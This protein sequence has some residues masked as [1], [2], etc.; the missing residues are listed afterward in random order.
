MK[1]KEYTSRSRVP[2]A[3]R[4][5]VLWRTDRRIIIMLLEM[6]RRVMLACTLQYAA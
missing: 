4:Q 2:M 3:Y 5:D 1:S 6:F